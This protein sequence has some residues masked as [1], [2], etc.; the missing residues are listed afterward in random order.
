MEAQPNPPAP[1]PQREGRERG[2]RAGGWGLRRAAIIGL[3]AGTVAAFMVWFFA[4]HEPEPKN[5][6]KRFQGDW[7]LGTPGRPDI[8]FVR[9]SGDRWQY[10]SNGEDVRGPTA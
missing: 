7:K 5:D 10:I 3:L 9:V 1:F 2:N 4:F 8:T 6:Y